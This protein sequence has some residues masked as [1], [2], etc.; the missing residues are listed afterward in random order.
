MS[1]EE[2]NCPIST[3]GRH[4]SYSVTDIDITHDEY[5]DDFATLYCG[6]SMEHYHLWDTPQTIISDGAY[7]VLGFD[8]DTSDHLGLVEWY[9]KH[10]R[11]WSK[12]ATA[13]TTLWF[14]NSEL[15]WAA[16]HPILEKYGWRY[17]SCNTWNKGKGHI[18]GNVNTNTIRRFPV[19]TE[20]CVQYVFEA[21]VDNMTLQEWVI[22]EW[23]RAGLKRKEADPACGVKNAASRK[24]L[25]PGHLWYFPPVDAFEKMVLYANS[26]GKQEGKPYYSLDGQKPI[27]PNEWRKMRAKFNCPHGVSNVWERPPLKGAERIK[28]PKGKKVAHLNQKPLDLMSTI[29]EASTDKG[30]V[31]WEPFGGLFSAS[32]AA[33]QLE[34]RA[35][36]CEIDPAYYTLGVERFRQLF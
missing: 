31:I 16:V 36:S 14:W 24:Y 4:R 32:L 28:A 19:T 7:G 1:L 9:E 22:S 29:I 8:G 21:K 12:K 17:V 35:F 15:G 25:D 30:D 34:R 2:K 26:N 27:T 10:I 3:V 18:A 5:T 23:K 20:V 13:E 11:E 33:K 6:D